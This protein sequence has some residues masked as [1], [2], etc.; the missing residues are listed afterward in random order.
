MKTLE[1]MRNINPFGLRLQPDLKTQLEAAAE[2]NKRSLN[3][4]ISARLEESL[5]PPAA[6][7]TSV[8]K[9]LDLEGNNYFRLRSPHSTYEARDQLLTCLDSLKP[10]ESVLLVVRDGDANHSALSVVINAQDFGLLA[11]KTLMTAERPPRESEVRSLVQKL[12]KKNLL[13]GQTQFRTKRMTEQTKDLSAKD[14]VLI[15]EDGPYK[16]LTLETLQEF[17]TLF[18]KKPMQ[19]SKAELNRFLIDE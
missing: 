3:A 9:I 16:A 11:D 1:S 14:A 8:F 4:E 12:N 15:I 2:K 19:Y 7:L 17:L 18:H 13:N 6:L 5:T 10:I